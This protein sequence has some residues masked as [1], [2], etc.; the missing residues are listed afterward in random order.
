MTATTSSDV[1]GGESEFTFLYSNDV[2][3]ELDVVEDSPE[4]SGRMGRKRT[5]SPETWTKKFVKGTGL[6]KNSP[7]LL[8]S[9]ET[10][11]CKKNCLKKFKKAHLEKLR[12]TFQK[13]SYD[14]QNV[15][16]CGHL[17][18]QKTQKVVVIH[19]KRNHQLLQ[20]VKELVDLLPKRVNSVS[21][22]LYVMK[23]M[24]MW[25]SVRRGSAMCWAL[26]LNGFRCW[27]GNSMQE[28]F[29]QTSVASMVTISLL[30]KIQEIK[31]ELIII[32]NQT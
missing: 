28:K 15:F 4:L 17:H 26:D 1:C 21:N 5:R 18:S 22:T 3:K 13:L 14:E 6:R 10:S 9:E 30:V 12:D 32:S 23:I 31:L 8:I 25:V 7:L 27:G 2:G 20:V 24:S 16:L 29:S 19:A 11:C